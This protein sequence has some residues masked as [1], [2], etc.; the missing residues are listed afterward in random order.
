MPGPTTH[1]HA[2]SH[3]T[4][5]RKQNSLGKI[6]RIGASCTNRIAFTPAKTCG[7]ISLL[8]FGSSGLEV[9]FLRLPFFVFFVDTKF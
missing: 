5:F 3:R 2:L 9:S 4:K 7:S 8:H 1:S 6:N